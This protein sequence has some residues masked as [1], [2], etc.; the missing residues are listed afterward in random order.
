MPEYERTA[1]RTR[2]ERAY[3]LLLHVDPRSFRDEFGEAMVQCFRDRMAP[4]AHA[5]RPLARLSVWQKVV[6]DI[7]RNAVPSH[8]DALRHALRGRRQH[9]LA[10]ITAPSLNASR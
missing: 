4:A 5:G 9:Q 2:S 6:A 7:A 8:V 1:A 10:P 3:R